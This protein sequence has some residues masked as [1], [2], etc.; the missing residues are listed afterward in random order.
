MY[1][2]YILHS[3]TFDSFYIGYTSDIEKRL[4]E[5]NSGLTR[6]TKAKRP[7]KLVYSEEY[8]DKTLSIKRERFLKA[9]KSKAF[10]K[11]LAGLL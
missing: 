6:S 8:P 1:T 10:Y 3:T 11:K 4:L 9:Q 7:W 2:V 5:H